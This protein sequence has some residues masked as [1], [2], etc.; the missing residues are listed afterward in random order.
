MKINECIAANLKELKKAKGYTNQTLAQISGV[1]INT[2]SKIV[3]GITT[4]P[5]VN[6][7]IALGDALDCKIWDFFDD[8]RGFGAHFSRDEQ[9]VLSDYRSLSAEGRRFMRNQLA[10]LLAYEGELMRE[11]S[12][13]YRVSLPLYLLPTSAGTGEFLD[14]DAY[15]MT[16]F[17]GD[18][19][20][21]GSHFAVR[22]SGDSMEPSFHDHQV[23][24]IRQSRSI[25][26][27]EVGIFILNGEGYI[28]ELQ[29]GEDG[30]F[31]I[32][33]NPAY[34]PIAIGLEDDLRV[35]GK[36]LSPCGQ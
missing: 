33:H 18:L 30:V 26:S 12:E 7:L 16:A 27:G 28:K 29:E 14:S 2:L 19:V 20:P 24:F 3:C 10:E 15:E 13:D 11:K 22:I 31:L 8:G 9:S 25:A 34:S 32:S 5:T 1:P 36:V 21:E 35:V 17:S 6:T 23:V 4:N